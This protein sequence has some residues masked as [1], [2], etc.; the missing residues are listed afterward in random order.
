M[1]QNLALVM[2]EKR[3]R[4]QRKSMILMRFCS[5]GGGRRNVEKWVLIGL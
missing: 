2:K 3:S 5:C 4:D 1:Q